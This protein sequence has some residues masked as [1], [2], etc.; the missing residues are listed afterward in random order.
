MQRDDVEAGAV[1]DEVEDVHADVA[2][3]ALGAVLRGEPPEPALLGAPVAPVPAGEPGLQVARLDVADLADLAGLDH[4]AGGLDRGGVAVGEVHHVDRP[5]AS[6]ASVIARASAWFSASGFS[7]K[8]GLPAARSSIVV[9][10]CDAVGGRVDGGVELA[11][12]DRVGEA[13]EGA[14]D[15]VGA[16]EVAGA[17]GVGVDGG[18]ELAAGDGGEALGV[19]AGDGAGAEDQEPLV[20]SLTGSP[21]RRRLCSDGPCGVIFS[22]ARST[23]TFGASATSCQAAAGL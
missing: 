3:H 10:L 12:G 6:A 4:A 17:L 19:V 18:D 5:A 7:Q 23:G 16:G 2:E 21:P 11:P 20:P 13:A 9:G 14:G 1:G 15:G 8:T 22:G